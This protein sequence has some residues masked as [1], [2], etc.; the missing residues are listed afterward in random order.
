MENDHIN[1]SIHEA[2]KHLISMSIFR[3]PSG[4]FLFN[5]LLHHEFSTLILIFF[6]S[7]H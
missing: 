6:D 4:L 5:C 2:Q 1:K 3:S 7:N